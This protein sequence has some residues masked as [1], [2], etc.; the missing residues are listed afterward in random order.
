MTYEQ[1]LD[2]V[3]DWGVERITAFIENAKLKKTRDQ[4]LTS[5]EG[6][7]V[8]SK[9]SLMEV[10]KLRQDAGEFVFYL[11][12]DR[13]RRDCPKTFAEGATEQAKNLKVYVWCPAGRRFNTMTLQDWLDSEEHLMTA[14]L[15]LGDG[16]K[17][18][19]KLSH[20]LA[21]ELA[22]GYAKELYVLAKAMDPLG[23][24]SH[25]GV[26]KKAGALIITDADFRTTKGAMSA[27]EVKS[28]FD[29]QDGGT[30]QG[31]RYRPANFPGS[32]ELPRIFNM[33]ASAADM[34]TFF[35]KHDMFGIALV[36]EELAKDNLQGAATLLRDLDA[37][38]QAQ[39]RRFAVACC[40]QGESLVTEDTIATLRADAKARAAA[41][42]K[43]REQ[44]HGA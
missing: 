43:R 37:D 22:I 24:L 2:V 6:V 29:I 1:A 18:K 23:I 38:A 28:V 3:A 21:Q 34:G 14:L 19:S 41:A 40:V 27:E 30:V 11:G 32:G 31:T 35:R 42:K 25:T 20:M 10:V 7:C 36:L 12:A 4:T 5:L 33:N 9:A 16:G 26:F 15:L 44:Y 17:G 8:V 39:V 13:Q